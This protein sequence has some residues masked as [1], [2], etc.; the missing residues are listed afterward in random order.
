MI[1]RE[2][3]YSPGKGQKGL[4]VIGGPT[5]AGKTAL[6]VKIAERLNAGIISADSAQVYRYLDI[7]TAKPSPEERKAAEHHLI[8]VVDPGY[9]YSVAR[10]QEEATALIEQMYKE[11]KLPLLVGGTGLYI[12]AVTEGYAFGKK[13]ADQNLRLALE[14]AAEKYGL[15]LLYARLKKADPRAALKI[16]PNDKKRII[17]ALEVYSLEGKPISEQETATQNKSSPYRLQF[18]CISMERDKLYRKI[19]QRVEHMFELGWVDEVRDLLDRGYDENDPGLQ[20]LGYR[21]V[22]A[23]L[24]GK[25]SLEETK[26]EIKKQTRNLAKRQL[27]WFRRRK[28]TRWVNI[29]DLTSLDDL[30]D[31][32]CSEVKDLLPFRANTTNNIN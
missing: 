6:A 7:G 28:E 18:I 20:V 19:E 29:T 9:N 8:D 22:I 4:L 32:I 27:T 1:Y 11:N 23:L 24:Q 15:T 21:Q 14:D 31:N 25:K 13:G 17:R 30:A 16:H 10:F 12:N 26:S 5:A 2:N 3:N